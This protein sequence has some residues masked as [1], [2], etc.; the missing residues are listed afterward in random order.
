MIF[1]WLRYGKPDVSM[2]LN[3]SLAGLVAIT[4]PCDVTDALGAL[5]IGAVSG[6]LVVLVY[7]SVTMWLMWMTRL[8]AVAVHCL[9]GI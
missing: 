1:T 7:G 6:V 8:G 3:A 5:I 2:C 4:A 9:N